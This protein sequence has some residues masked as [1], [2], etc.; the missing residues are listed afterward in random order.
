MVKTKTQ[1][2]LDEAEALI[3]ILTDELIEVKKILAS[4]KEDRRG[5][6][7]GI[8]RIAESGQPWKKT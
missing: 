4:L 3:K 7:D 5:I 6:D 1:K 2:R 8:Y